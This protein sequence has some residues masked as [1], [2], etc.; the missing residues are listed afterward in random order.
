MTAQIVIED[1]LFSPAFD[2]LDRLKK[3]EKA[4]KIIISTI[5]SH[6]KLFLIFIE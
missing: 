6:K 5:K 2:G 3:Q 1:S 4:D